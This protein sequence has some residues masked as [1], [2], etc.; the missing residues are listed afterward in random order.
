[1][2][3]IVSSPAIVPTASGSRARSSAIGER[4]RLAA[5][6]RMTTSCCTRSTRRRNSAAARSSAVERRLG[7][8]RVGAG[9]LVGAVAGAL[10]QAELL[11]VARDRRLRR[12]EAAL[13]QAAAQL[14][15]AV[16]R[17]AIDEF[18]DERPGGALSSGLRITSVR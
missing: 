7:I 16:E 8:G 13:V 3:R 10:D 1:M 14:L 17:L 5:P 12:L 18:E 9:P 2:T 11:D 15:L 6:V 4:L